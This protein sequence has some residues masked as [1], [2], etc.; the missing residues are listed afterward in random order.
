MRADLDGPCGAIREIGVR[1]PAPSATMRAMEPTHD[2]L[3]AGALAAAEAGARVLAERFGGRRRIE[4]K[5]AID[6][7]T[8]ADR[9]AEAAIVD[10]IRARFP[11]HAIL[12]EEGGETGESRFRWIVDPLDGTTN[13][14]H[15]LPQFCTS[16]ACEVDG[17]IVA[18]AIVDPMREERF[19]A[20]RGGGA[21]LDG[22]RLHVGDT[23]DLQQ[24][25]LATGFPYWVHER[26]DEPLA[27]FGAF[28]RVARGVRRYGSAALD[29]AWLAA[30]RYDG[31]FEMG[32]KPWDLAAGVLLV[33]EAGGVCSDL[34][35]GPLD[36][37]RGDVV[38]AGKALHPAMI[39]T[40]RAA[41]G[42]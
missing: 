33:E 20:V 18:G 27:L 3:L 13:Y 7:V 4:H 12:A 15:G 14:A 32:L 39:A 11:A 35:G 21:F 5:G 17:S 38:A 30:G 31:F 19:T 26:P 42:R 16:V 41:R 6:L 22:E 40:S 28:V 23:A 25:L 34:D 8:D 10:A 37:E 2:E 24:A 1:A 9:A 36:L 29:L